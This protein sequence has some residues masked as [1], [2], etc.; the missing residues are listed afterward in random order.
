MLL[1][2]NV[3]LAF[4]LILSSWLSR[5]H[6]GKFWLAGFAGLPFPFLWLG[7]L[8]FIPLWFFYRK[9][10]W[11]ISL[12]AILACIQSARATWGIHLFGGS[13]TATSG[14]FT[15]MTFNCSSLGLREYKDVPE[16]RE[17]IYEE[18]NKAKPDV[19]CMQEFYSNDHPEKVNNLD[20]IRLKF[21]FPYYFFVK[22]F[23]RWDTW[24]F[25]TVLFSR[26]PIVDTSRV[27]LFGGYEAEDLLCAKLLVQK[28][29]I[30]IFSAHL[31]SYKL[32]SSDYETVS[33]AD[34]SRVRGLLGKMRRSFKLRSQQA[35]ILR[36]EIDSCRLPL[37]V[38]GDFND[39][40]V[41]YTYRTVRGDLQDAFLQQ[42]SGFGRT[43]S[44]LSPTL[45]IDYVLPD[46]HFRVED[47]AIYRR[48]GFEHFPVMARLSLS[49]SK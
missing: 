31:A 2:S 35:G 28:D 26:F 34:N 21:G 10:Y 12:V 44:A 33:N 47:F 7:S 3:L 18:I 15:V 39:I 19:L 45:R 16:F 29:T 13:K 17:R 43:F 42:G 46:R 14:S 40:P 30:R 22:S 5:L 1:W 32:E 38:V 8:L 9:K 27:E 23:T 48:K 25:G 20:S 6:P 41:S 49:K 24:H 36:Q 4:A 37:I 11:V